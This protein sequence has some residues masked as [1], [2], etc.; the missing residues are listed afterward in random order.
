MTI[1]LELQRS[2]RNR[3]FISN[4]E[5]LW[6]THGRPAHLLKPS[7]GNALCAVVVIARNFVERVI[8]LLAIAVSVARMPPHSRG[9]EA[10]ACP[11][12]AQASTCF[13]INH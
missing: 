10:N 5:A 4:C 11:R 8:V 1:C 3:S 6:R 9:G 12:P 7:F 2:Q 13:G